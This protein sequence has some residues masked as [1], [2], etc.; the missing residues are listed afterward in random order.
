MLHVE[1]FE[2]YRSLLFSIAYRMLGSVHDAEDL[3][4]ETFLRWQQVVLDEVQAPKSYLSA[5]ITR[6]C[7]DQLRSARVQRE[8]Y[9]GPWLPEPLLTAAPEPEA[10]VALAESL[11]LAFLVLMERL[12]ATDRAV[13]L[14]HD[15]FDYSFGEIGTIVGKSAAAC[16]QIAHRARERI[17]ADRPRFTIDP[18][19]IERVTQQFMQACASGDLPALMHTLA[20]DA[21]MIS[22]GGGV[23]AAARHPLYGA[24]RI[25]RFMTG[26]LQ[27]FPANLTVQPAWINGQSGTFIYIDGQLDSVMLLEINMQ[28]I[29]RLYFVR[30]P[31]KLR[32]ITAKNRP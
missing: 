16:R 8:Q 29:Q 15:I 10:Q 24:E 19:Q 11:S 2:Q 22:D 7:I 6:L 28:H 32:S 4:Q 1:I 9:I 25:A 3:V 31:A 27:K 30:N 12:N 21:V 23:V 17:A 14:L 20:E 13:F 5:V 26:L 18:A